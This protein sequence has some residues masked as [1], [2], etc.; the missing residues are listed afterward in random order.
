MCANSGAGVTQGT[1]GPEQAV[2]RAQSP[3][4]WHGAKEQW[5]QQAC[6]SETC[7][8]A[9]SQNMPCPRGPQLPP[10]PLGTA[11]LSMPGLLSPAPAGLWGPTVDLPVT[12]PGEAR[13]GRQES[14]EKQNP[15]RQESNW[16]LS[17]GVAGGRRQEPSGPMTLREAVA[18][19]LFL[20]SFSS[21]EPSVVSNLHLAEP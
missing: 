17:G 6:S 1:A 19:L 14:W 16:P 2:C 15:R 9:A 20:F 18:H 21:V 5:A 7:P 12:T 3:G 4:P 11:A 10:F 8:C 13:P